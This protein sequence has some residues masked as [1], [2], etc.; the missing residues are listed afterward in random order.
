MLLEIYHAGLISPERLQALKHRSSREALDPQL[1]KQAR[2]IAERVRAGGDAAVIETTARFDGV[3]LKPDQLRVSDDEFAQARGALPADVIAA[4]QTAIANHRRYNEALLPPTLTLFN[5]ADGIIGGRKVSPIGRVALYVP[6]GKG[7]YPSTFITIAV[8]AVVAGVPEIEILVPPRPDGTIDPAILFAADMLGT[9]HILRA[10]GVAAISAAAIG[11]DAL[12]KVMKIVGPGSPM[13]I[14]SQYYAQLQGVDVALF[15]GPTECMIVADDSA[16]PV[17][18]AADL[19]NEAEHGPDSS[20]ILLT[21][22]VALA[23]SVQHEVERQLPELPERRRKFARSAIERYG[24]AVVTDDL[25]QAVELANEWANE[26]IQVVTRDPW[27][28]VHQLVHASEI[29]VGQSTPFS[30]ISY[31]IGVPA[32]LPTGQFARIY[33]PVTVD[34]YLRNAA[35]AALDERGLRSLAPTVTALAHH[36][37]F[38]AH[39]RSIELRSE[40]GFFSPPEAAA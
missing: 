26:H 3:V 15:F 24:G 39:A 11:T 7:S 22:S 12:P 6:S 4:I 28:I 32:C 2:Q 27:T 29:L 18:V 31:A 37:D 20:A 1:F 38:P 21:N 33:S 5:I 34:T 8:P 17:L 30:A 19:L 23:E 13:I 16:N 36:E 14:A 40:N 25:D 35:V 10:N 9:R